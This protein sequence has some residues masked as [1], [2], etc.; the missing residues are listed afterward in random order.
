[1]NKLTTVE[2]I[3]RFNKPFFADNHFTDAQLLLEDSTVWSKRNAKTLQV[4][5]KKTDKN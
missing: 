5:Y 2:I 3:G 4:D 1:M